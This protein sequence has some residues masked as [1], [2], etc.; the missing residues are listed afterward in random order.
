MYFLQI[1]LVNQSLSLYLSY[2][3]LET[4]LQPSGNLSKEVKN[5]NFPTTWQVAAVK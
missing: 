3:D 2:T 5:V 1:D 4:G